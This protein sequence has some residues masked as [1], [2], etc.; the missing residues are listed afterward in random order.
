SWGWRNRPMLEKMPKAVGRALQKVRA[1]TADL[2]VTHNEITGTHAIIEL[3]SPAFAYNEPIP[4][5]YTADGLGFSPPLRW[6]GVPQQA[7]SLVLLI[8]DADSPTPE[9]LVHAIAWDLPAT[10]ASLG[11]GALGDSVQYGG[12]RTLGRNSFLQERYA[13]PDPPPGHG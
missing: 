8:E 13:P 1:S 7:A 3:S 5:T 6:D 10:D 11:P 12:V 4:P 2:A 9:P